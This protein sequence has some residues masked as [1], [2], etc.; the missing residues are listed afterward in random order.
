MSPLKIPVWGTPRP[1]RRGDTALLFDSILH[2]PYSP[3]P[4]YT[5]HNSHH[6]PHLSP[7]AAHSPLA[8]PPTL[9]ACP[10]HPLPPPS[11]RAS[12]PPQATQVA[13]AVAAGL[14]APTSALAQAAPA[15][16]A[17][18]ATPRSRNPR[19]AASSS[20]HNHTAKLVAYP[21]GYRIATSLSHFFTCWV[22]YL[23]PRASDRLSQ[24][25]LRKLSGRA[26]PRAAGGH[27]GTAHPAHAP[28][29]RPQS[30]AVGERARE[31]QRA[32]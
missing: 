11:A 7:I 32:R 27:R 5:E 13:A 18:A 22:A 17:V 24:E 10:P 12:P 31:S 23:E 3:P 21:I 2:T 29:R 16:V 20:G 25:A 14:A 15:T 19:M 8:T 30:A 9:S 6:T 28:D 4:S 26:P 1:S